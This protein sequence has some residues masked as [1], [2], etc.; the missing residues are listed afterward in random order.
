MKILSVAGLSLFLYS[1]AS[2]P[3]SVSESRE[4]SPGIELLTG[5]DENRRIEWRAV[6]STGCSL[7]I[8]TPL[9]EGGMDER[10]VLSRHGEEYFSNSD[11]M[12]VLSAS[13]HT[14]IRFRS[15]FPQS[16]IG[17]YRIDGITYSASD[18]RHDALG[19]YKNGKPELLHPGEQEEWNN[20]S[21]GGF[22]AILSGGLPLSPVSVRDAV[23][24]IGW[25]EDGTLIIYLVIR[26]KEGRGYSYEEAGRLLKS[27]G[28]MEGIA[29]D[30]GGSAR[31]VWREDESLRSFPL[32]PLYRAVPNHLLL[33][34]DQV[35]V[36]S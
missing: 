15:G 4:I 7:S 13:P 23:C 16:V 12:A 31:L 28:A 1:C 33:L 18:G 2:S 30:G 26:G 5:R 29:M 34:I 35:G 25:S 10:I 20:D 17:L 6:R 8:S 27:L 21:A 22:Y 11:V 32:V 19:V 9:S 36:N 14:P 3:D 24:A